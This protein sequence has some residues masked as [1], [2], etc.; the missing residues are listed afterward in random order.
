MMN[1]KH[2]ISII[3]AIVLGLM[4]ALGVPG[5][6][7][8][9]P[10]MA[11]EEK[12]ADLSAISGFGKGYTQDEK[13]KFEIEGVMV[14]HGSMYNITVDGESIQSWCGE[15]RGRFWDGEPLI[16]LLNDPTTLFYGKAEG[17]KKS[18]EYSDPVEFARPNGKSF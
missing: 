7:F 2:N 18:S 14:T 15:Q 1:V 6:I 17:T 8:Q 3:T 4:I 11:A 9:V 10:C 16:D 13:G 5:S 12:K